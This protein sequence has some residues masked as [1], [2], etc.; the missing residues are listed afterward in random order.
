MIIKYR[1]QAYRTERAIKEWLEIADK[2]NNKKIPVKDIANQYKNRIT[3]KPYTI[4]YIYWI[5]KRVQT[6]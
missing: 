1:G 5:L 3:G 6:L 4:S 2:Y